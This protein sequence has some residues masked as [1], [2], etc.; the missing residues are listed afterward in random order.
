MSSSGGR[1]NATRVKRR[2]PSLVALQPSTHSEH[3]AAA[4]PSSSCSGASICGTRSLESSTPSTNRSASGLCAARVASARLASSGEA[5]HPATAISRS[6]ACESSE[7]RAASREA[8]CAIGQTCASPPKRPIAYIV[9][10]RDRSSRLRAS[11]GL[12]AERVAIDIK[13]TLSSICNS[14]RPQ[15]MIPSPEDAPSKDVVLLLRKKTGLQP[16]FQLS[17][18]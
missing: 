12:A 17:N 14:E 10:R 3:T 16:R 18:R 7:R 11:L 4:A 8:T 5:S 2:R 6:C 1:L 9:G 15:S 13:P